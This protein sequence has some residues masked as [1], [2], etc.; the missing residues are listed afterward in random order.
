[1]DEWTNTSMDRPRNRWTDKAFNRVPD[2]KRVKKKGERE[3]I[4]RRKNRKTSENSFRE[5]VVF[6][7]ILQ[8]PVFWSMKIV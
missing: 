7:Q 3:K 2:K 5:A 1:M 6:F 8:T 4:K